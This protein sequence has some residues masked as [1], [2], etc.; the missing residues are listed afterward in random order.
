[1]TNWVLYEMSTFY[2]YRWNQLKIIPMACTA[3][4]RR[5]P[6]PKN[7]LQHSA[8]LQKWRNITNSFA[9]WRHLDPWRSDIVK[10]RI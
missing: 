7:T 4:T 6:C 5:A 3:R 10:L 2:S 1:M 8:V 9:K